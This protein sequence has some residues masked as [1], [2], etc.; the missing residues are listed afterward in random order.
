MMNVL[1]VPD[2]LADQ[3]VTIVVRVQ[4]DSD[5]RAERTVL[6]T[7]G[8]PNQAPVL[9]TGR[10]ADLPRLIDQAWI[11]YGARSPVP[12]APTATV[13]ATAVVSNDEADDD[14]EADSDD[15]DA[16]RDALDE[17]VVLPGGAPGTDPPAP[18][19]SPKASILSLF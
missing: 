15:P 9:V 6:A 11:R 2:P 1:E 10:L 8:L 13:V 5:Q 4:A 7:V 14:G 16:G 12:A 3:E 17:G 18:V 19:P